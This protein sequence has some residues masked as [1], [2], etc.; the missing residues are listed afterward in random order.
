MRKGE[1]FTKIQ[2]QSKLNEKFVCPHTPQWINSSQI[3]HNAIQSLFYHLLINWI[4]CVRHW[5]LWMQANRRWRNQIDSIWICT[6][7]KSVL[8]HIIHSFVHFQALYFFF[9]FSLF[10]AMMHF[11]ALTEAIE[12]KISSHDAISQ[13][14]YLDSLK[15]VAHCSPSRKWIS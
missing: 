4:E 3:G 9:C 5:F 10:A 8:E 12:H 15:S 7:F 1:K 14:S 2:Y 13:Y 11:Y 6:H